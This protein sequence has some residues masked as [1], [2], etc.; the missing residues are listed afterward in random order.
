MIE[1]LPD[2]IDDELWEM[3]CHRAD[4]L[5]NFVARNP[6]KSSTASV[7]ELAKELDLS[8]ASAYRLIK[9]F[10]KGGTVTSLV[11]RKRGRPSGHRALDNTR[12][13]I[14]RTTIKQY[15]LKK[16]RPTISQLVRDVQ[17]NC[18][19]ASLTVNSS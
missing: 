19:S 9:L 7:D 18:I 14:I 2:E 1:P 4:A 3:A 10:R 11:D 6:Y 16:T 5:Q 17:M 12:E 15:F 8:R 13:D